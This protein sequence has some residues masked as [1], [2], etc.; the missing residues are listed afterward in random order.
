MKLI[1][2]I[3]SLVSGLLNKEGGHIDAQDVFIQAVTP[4]PTCFGTRVYLLSSISSTAPNLI[5][6][7]TCYYVN[8]P[9]TI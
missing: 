7:S 9:K 1:L 3:G 4:L 6:D 2:V 5:K 8:V